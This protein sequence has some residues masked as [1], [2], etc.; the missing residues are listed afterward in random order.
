[1]KAKNEISREY[2]FNCAEQK[3]KRN[4]EE[5]SCFSVE[6]R[7]VSGVYRLAQAGRCRG[8]EMVSGP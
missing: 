5:Q 1:M 2:M 3:W 7:L 6:R 8:E 4:V